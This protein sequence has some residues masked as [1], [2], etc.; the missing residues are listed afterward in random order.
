MRLSQVLIK[1]IDKYS[2]LSNVQKKKYKMNISM[3]KMKEKQAD[4][5][6]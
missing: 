1:S 4:K 5:V 6:A 2:E 3:F